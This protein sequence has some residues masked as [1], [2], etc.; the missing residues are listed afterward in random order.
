MVCFF[1][2]CS[3]SIPR[4]IGRNP[5]KPG[6]SAKSQEPAVLLAS[7]PCFGHSLVTMT[8]KMIAWF[9][10]KAFVERYLTSQLAD[11]KRFGMFESMNGCFTSYSREVV[12]KLV[13]V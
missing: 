9:S 12:Q 3:C 6:L 2:F 10:R 13:Q 1:R 5:W 8:K 11:H 7:K 4:S